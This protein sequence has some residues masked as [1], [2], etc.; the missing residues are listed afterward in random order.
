MPPDSSN[1]LTLGEGVYI[2]PDARIHPSTRGTRI[3]IGAHTQIYDFVCIRAVG[4]AGDL[5]MGEHCYINPHCVMFTGNGIT[6]GDYVLLAPGVMLMPANHAFGR[7]DIPVRHQGFLESKGGIFIEDDVW[8]GA[9]S[10]IL[11][12]THIGKGAIIAAGSVVRGQVPPYEIWGGTL[13]VKIKSRP[14]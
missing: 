6:L 10:V 8:I 7:R 2:S 13:A 14:A 9:N 11:D 3:I 5:V 1:A 12:G 4:G